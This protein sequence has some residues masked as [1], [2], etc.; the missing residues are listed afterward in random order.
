MRKWQNQSLCGPAKNPARGPLPG[1][2]RQVIELQLQ[3]RVEKAFCTPAQVHRA[4]R[5]A[6]FRN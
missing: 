6:P 2:Y 5:Q 3:L 1:S 4:S